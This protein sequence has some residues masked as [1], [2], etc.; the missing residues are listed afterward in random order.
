MYL[1]RVGNILDG[2]GETY[3]FD[4]L[5]PYQDTHPIGVCME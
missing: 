1:G 5:L 2:G 4:L 3:L